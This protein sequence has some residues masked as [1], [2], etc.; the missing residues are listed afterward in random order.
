MPDPAPFRSLRRRGARRLS[1]LALALA[2]PACTVPERTELLR[3][4]GRRVAFEPDDAIQRTDGT[5]ALSLVTRWD[6]ARVADGRRWNR[7]VERLLLRCVPLGR[8]V[9]RTS[10]Y[11]DDGPTLGDLPGDMRDSS[12][13]AP[14]TPADSAVL[15][16]ACAMLERR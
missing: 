16:R 7:E 14:P 2:L 15:A 11:L 1:L 10:R 12:W 4:D 6:S 9:M 8:R 5:W 3:E 13:Q